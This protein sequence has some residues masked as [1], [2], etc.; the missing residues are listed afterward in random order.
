MSEEG[1]DAGYVTVDGV[2]TFY[3][4][5]GPADGR[6]VVM[7][8][9]AGADGLEWR[10]VLPVLGAEGYH[11][12]TLDFP[13]HGKSLPHPDGHIDSMHEFAEFV[14]SFVTTMGLDSPVVAGCSIGGDVVLDL[15]AHHADDLDG[16]VCLEGALRTPTYPPGFLSMMATASGFPAF[17]RFYHHASRHCHG[18]RA[19]EERVTE[20]AF[21]HQHAIQEVTHA[22][23]TAWNDHDVRE[24]AERITCPVLYV[25]GEDDYFLPV[26]YVEETVAALSSVEFV[27]MEGIGHYPMLETDAFTDRL[28]SF[29]D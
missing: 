7:V 9:T 13:G 22:D 23:L 10:H 1:I 26:E 20:H 21:L 17:P 5:C 4:E 8:H 29:L 15:A 11:A 19:I 27:R 3:E 14:W 2:R 28:L 18:E 12:L 25:F 16:V 24:R 6:D